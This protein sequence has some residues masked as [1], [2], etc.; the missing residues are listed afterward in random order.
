[1]NECWFACAIYIRSSS[2]LSLAFFEL[3]NNTQL[4]LYNEFPYPPSFRFQLYH[5]PALPFNHDGG[6]V[7]SG[8]GGRGRGRGREEVQSL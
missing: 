1:M 4:I 2:D 8:W 5:V 3:F 7:L 6:I